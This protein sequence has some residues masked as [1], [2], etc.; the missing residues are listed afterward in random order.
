MH[1]TAVLQIMFSDFV[2]MNQSNYEILAGCLKADDDEVSFTTV[3][4]IFEYF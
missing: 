1:I 3:K 4:I 2:G